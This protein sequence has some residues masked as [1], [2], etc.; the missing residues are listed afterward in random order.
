LYPAAKN[1]VYRR[2]PGRFA[3]IAAQKRRLR[4]LGAGQKRVSSQTGACERAAGGV[5]E[6]GAAGPEG[7]FS[8]KQFVCNGLREI[9][10]FRKSFFLRRRMQIL[11]SNAILLAQRGVGDDRRLRADLNEA[12]LDALAD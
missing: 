4:H 12:V 8:R 6:R 3:K 5:A 1:P 10:R 11:S 2:H 9:E 7:G